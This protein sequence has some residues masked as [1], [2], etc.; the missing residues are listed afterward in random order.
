VCE[1]AVAVVLELPVDVGWSLD[2]P[3]KKY[4]CAFDFSVIDSKLG[5]ICQGN[6]V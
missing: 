2:K 1:L 5:G 4:V 6:G 3:S